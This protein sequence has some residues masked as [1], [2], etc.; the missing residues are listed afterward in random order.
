[1]TV[2]QFKRPRKGSIPE[3]PQGADLLEGYSI[4]VMPRTAARIA[5]FRALLPGGTRVYIAHIDGTPV[6]DMVTTAARLAREGFTPV[7]HVPARLVPDAAAL[8]D[9]IARYQGEAGVCEALVLAGGL[10]A[11]RGAFDNAM[12]LLKTGLFGKAGFTRLMVAGHPEGNRD[13]DPSGG[14]A[15]VMAALRWK[16]RFAASSDARMGLATQFVFDAQPV[17]DWAGRLAAAGIDLPIHVGLAGPAKLQTLIK[18]AVT[19]GVGPSLRVLQRR[20]R[21]VTKLVTPFTP[22]AILAELAAHRAARPDSLI[23][24]IHLFPLG[25]IAASATWADGLRRDPARPALQP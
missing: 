15:N 4:E 24:G 16:Q 6:R 5:D 7:P 13:I 19:C 18:F 10:P 17:I 11:P 2:M 23:E 9:W 21:D 3:D 22:D 12:D 25:G 8:G 14:E 1:M 20:A